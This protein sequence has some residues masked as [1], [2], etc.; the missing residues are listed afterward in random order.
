MAKVKK[1]ARRWLQRS[2]ER[3]ADAD[4]TDSVRRMRLATVARERKRTLHSLGVP[5][6]VPE[7]IPS[8]WGTQTIFILGSGSS[9]C[10]M[11]DVQWELVRAHGSLG[12]NKWPLHDF[13]PT[14]YVF[15]P[16]GTFSRARVGE[17]LKR[18]DLLA[19]SP[20][21]WV[22]DS[23]LRKPEH[24]RVKIPDPLKRQLAVYLPFRW[25]TQR[26]DRLRAAVRTYLN[27]RERRGDPPSLIPG[28]GATIERMTV[29]AAVAGFTDIVLVGVD[30][31]TTEYFWERD[32][33]FLE[34]R[35]LEPFP[36]GQ[37]GPIH[38]T[39]MDREKYLPVTVTIPILAE[40]LEEHLSAQLW[41][42][43]ETS[44]LAGHV[45]VYDWSAL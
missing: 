14:A 19:A 2:V 22:S 37:T 20:E 33:S 11:S 26:A 27:W 43:S 42:A 35:N 8:R 7:E 39:A 6:L 25:G 21:V 17:A 31:N 5:E 13:L 23:V 29:L 30:L 40:M 9:I 36:S 4:G 38:A 16:F 3:V 28:T 41:I 24:L 15:E 45:P 12:V 18:E 1:R 32:P 34:R 44:A 10:D